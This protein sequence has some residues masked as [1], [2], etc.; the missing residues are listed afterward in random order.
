MLLINLN[1]GLRHARI[2][3]LLKFKNVEAKDR[4]NLN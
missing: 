3:N 2:N 4:L 1:S